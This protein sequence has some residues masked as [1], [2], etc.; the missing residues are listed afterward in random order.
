LPFAQKAVDAQPD[1]FVTHNALGRVLL[2]VGKVPEAIKELEIGVKQAPDS[3]EMRFALARAYAK[4]GRREDARRERELFLQL[5]KQAREQR[6]GAQSVGGVDNK[7]A[8]KQ[9][10]QR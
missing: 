5:D 6:E 10:P 4:A 9:P 1:F 7:P 8:D 2:E 3:P